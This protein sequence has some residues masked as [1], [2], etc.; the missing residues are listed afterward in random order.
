MKKSKA[1]KF[2]TE[3]ILKSSHFRA[4]KDLLSVVLKEETE[5]SLEEVSLLVDKFMKGKVN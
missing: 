5:Y 4:N 1:N 2:L 3:Q